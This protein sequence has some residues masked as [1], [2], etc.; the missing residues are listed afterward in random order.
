MAA[1]KVWMN[2]L[3]AA[4]VSSMGGNP[5]PDDLLAVSDEIARGARMV[6]ELQSVNLSFIYEK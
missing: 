3:V 4:S 6:A 5:T 1:G 2:V